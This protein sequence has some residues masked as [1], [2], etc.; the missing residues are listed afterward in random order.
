MLGKRLVSTP[1]NFIYDR[2]LKIQKDCFDV[3]VCDVYVEFV[4]SGKGK[5]HWIWLQTRGTLDAQWNVVCG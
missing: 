5:C 1:H 2:N 4:A 3:L